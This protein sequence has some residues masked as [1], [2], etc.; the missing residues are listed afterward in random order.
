MSTTRISLILACVVVALGATSN[1]RADFTFGTPVNLGPIVNSPSGDGFSCVSADGLEMY[2]DS[3]RPGGRGNWDIWV[4]KRASTDDSWGAPENL[5]P[6]VNTSAEEGLAT[7]SADGLTLHFSSTGR[8]GG[9]GGNDIYAVTRP[10]K[11]DPWGPAV[12][13][14][15]AVNSPRDDGSVWFSADGLELFYGSWRSS[16]Y[17]LSDVYTAKRVTVNDPWGE[18]ANLGPVVNTTNSE[19]FPYLSPDGLVLFFSDRNNGPF[20][21]G[22]YG[23]G[24]LW[25]ARR[26]SRSDPW[27][28]PVNLGP[29]V[30]SLSFDGCL[31]ISPDGRMLYFSSER[32][33]GFGGAWGDI[34]QAPILP[35]VDFNGDEKVDVNDLVTLIEHWGQN[36]PSVDIGPTPWGDGVVDVKDL[37]VLMRFWQQEILPS[38]LVAYWRLDETEGVVALDSVGTY[39][40]V[41]AGTPVWQRAGGKVGGALRFDGV[42]DYV[43]TPSVGNPS[44]GSFSVFVW[45]KGGAPG[46]I[47]V[48]QTG[49]V[50]WLLADAPGGRLRT[51]LS[52][53][54]SRVPAKPLVS[55][56]VI[57]DGGWHRVG[58]V[59]D[60]SNRILYVD[61]AEVARDTQTSLA[62][63][64]G[65]LTLG[66]GSTLVPGTFWKG[67]SDDV[68]I[69]NGAV[70]P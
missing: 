22:G 7:I 56:S 6:T 45:V 42:D 60:G 18:P 46:Q 69:Y 50:D 17:G 61:D 34:W 27:Q 39:D 5:G 58:L 23:G 40:G 20:R 1:V 26:A 4:L 24:D 54:P 68:R 65:N 70:K 59:W 31:R 44:A 25:M 8:A 64:T 55:E 32:P 30:N 35:I 29:T 52:A 28:P 49:G 51:S 47:I 67:L 3:D 33:G 14:G 62:G 2:I 57:T 37:E 38:G 16:G 9:Y 11:T 12:N 10:T 21:P 19:D 48:S 15:P 53:P 13:L 63:S 41:L 36:E 43:T 66:A